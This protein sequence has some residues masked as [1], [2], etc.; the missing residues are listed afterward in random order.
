[1]SNRDESDLT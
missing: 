1:L